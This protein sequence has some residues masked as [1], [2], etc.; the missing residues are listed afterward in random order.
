MGKAYYQA[1]K[2]NWGFNSEQMRNLVNLL[3]TDEVKNAY[4]KAN[5]NGEIKFPELMKQMPSYF[6]DFLDTMAGKKG[7]GGGGPEDIF[8]YIYNAL[9]GDNISEEEW[10][11]MGFRIDKNGNLETGAGLTQE[12]MI[13]SLTE[14][15]I[16]EGMDPEAAKALASEGGA[17]AHTSGNI[18]ASM[19]D[20]AAELGLIN[21]LGYGINEASIT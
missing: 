16:A 21:L 19:E 3:G 9:G 10:A 18:G 7:K 15:L 6:T 5:R 11:E 13:E 17:I 2:S 4:Y 14:R 8:T 20:A 12:S 1:E